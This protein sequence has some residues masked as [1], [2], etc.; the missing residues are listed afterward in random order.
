M[1]ESIVQLDLH[2]RN[3]YQARVA[4]DT[5]LRRAGS[6]VY[7]IRV[8]HGW[9]AGTALRDFLH[10]EYARHPKVRRVAPGSNPGITELILR[11]Y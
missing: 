6:G 2:G 8:I 5:A 4:V 11:E 10:E 7:R 9:N 3:V 1:Y